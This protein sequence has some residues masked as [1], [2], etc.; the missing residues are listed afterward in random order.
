[1]GAVAFL[2]AHPQALE[3]VLLYCVCGAAGQVSL[4]P[5]ACHAPSLIVPTAQH[6]IF[7]AISSFGTVTNVTITTT[8]K[9]SVRMALCPGYCS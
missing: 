1:M 3:Q 2:I 4:R 9:V 6:F 5:S 7:M 8:R